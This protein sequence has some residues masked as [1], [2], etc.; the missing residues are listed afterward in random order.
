MDPME[1]SALRPYRVLDLTEGG[2]L[3]GARILADLGADV[4]KI[5]VPKGSSSRIAPYYQ[6]ID[7]PERSLFWFAYC[8]NKRGI[9]LDI[10]KAEGR[11]LFKKL[12]KSADVVME[13]FQPG[14]L[15]DL[16][17]GYSSLEEIN[18]IL[19]MTS[20]SLFGQNGPKACYKGSDL[21]AWA[22]G[23]YLY[24][25]GDPDRP[26]VWV[27]FPQASLLAGAES[28]CGTLTALWHRQMSG[29]GQH[30]DVSVQECVISPTMNT[31]IAWDL[32][33]VDTVR[34]GWAFR[35]M[36]TGVRI[37]QG[38][39]CK[40][41]YVVLHLMGGTA[42]NE[43]NM[44]SLVRW[45]DEEKLAPEWL[46][47]INW[48]HDYDAAKLSQ[49]LV[50]RVEDAV[51][52]FAMTKTKMEFYEEGIKRR[53]LVAP[54]SS[55]ADIRDNQQLDTRDYWVPLNHPELDA[56]LNYC[57]PF[58]KLSESPII[59]HRRAPLI[60]EHNEQIYEEEIGLSREQ[61]I[62]LTN[63]GII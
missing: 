28:S 19:V 24:L 58:A 52:K 53:I 39:K 21:T 7:H 35:I 10:E 3:I 61:I 46:R 26:P 33:E 6:S 60:G 27:S 48:I 37:R 18:P 13:S 47:Q 15:D 63:T 62:E 54:A 56:S 43:A 25:C 23:G 32:N 59:Y 17:L 57:G 36:A 30:V 42:L 5:E 31:T 55:P 40:D 45:M 34:P 50:D 49:D 44:N 1:H 14:Y 9:T 2:Y 4:I 20:I 38:V 41:G 11:N 16:E 51:E 12:V 22:S 8:A 29:Q